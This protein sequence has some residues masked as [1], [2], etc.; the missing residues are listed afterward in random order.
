MK[1]SDRRIRVT[2]KGQVRCSWQNSNYFSKLYGIVSGKQST[3]PQTDLIGQSNLGS[4]R[5]NTQKCNL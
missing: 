3:L 1:S 2:T 4:S 5:N